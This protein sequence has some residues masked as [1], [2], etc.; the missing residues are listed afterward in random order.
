[1]Q[2]PTYS[3]V[4]PVYNE[5]RRLSATLERVIGF[6]QQQHW[7]AEV[8]VVNDG[9]T[10]DT[11][12]IARSFS[13]RYPF[14]RVVENPGNHGKG[15]SVRNGMLHASGTFLLFSDA[16]LSAPIAESLK[17]FEALRAGADIALGSRWM[18]REL[19]RVAQPFYRRVLGRVF[20]L[21]LR[22]LLGLPYKDTQCGFKAFTRRAAEMV[23]PRQRV[24]RW[25]FDPEILFLAHRM[26]L[27]VAE[28]PVRWGHDTGSKI[29]LVRDGM[30]MAWDTI[31][32]RWSAIR[33]DYDVSQTCHPER[34]PREQRD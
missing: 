32:I 10:D 13:G 18:Q 12:D 27:K 22:A 25:G 4:I 34:S 29:H 15:Y 9:S 33:G 7:E 1:M 28:V 30:R 5:S 19:Q 31:K 26:G 14:V 23:F 16:D 24:T 20:N 21:L 11:P 17:L 3:I 2:P 8:V 6:V